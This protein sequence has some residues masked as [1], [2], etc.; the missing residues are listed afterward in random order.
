MG[1]S[2]IHNLFMDIIAEIEVVASRY[3]R[4]E[5]KSLVLEM[6]V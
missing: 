6:E 3:G 1:K 4:L 2:K 5:F